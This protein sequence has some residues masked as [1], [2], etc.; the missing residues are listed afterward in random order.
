[1]DHVNTYELYSR[2]CADGSPMK[3]N[4]DYVNSCS[5]VGSIDSN[6]LILAIA[7]SRKMKLNVLD[8]SN[9]LKTSV[10]FDPTERT[11]ITLPPF[12]LKWFLYNWPDYKLPSLL[13]K[14]LVIQCLHSI[15][16]TKDAS[17]RWYHLLKAKLQDLGMTTSML[18]H[19]V[20]IWS[21]QQHTCLSVLETDDLLMALNDDAPFHHFTTELHKMF[22]LTCCHGSVLKFLNLRLIQ[23]PLG[24]WFDQTNHIKTQILDPYFSKTPKTSI[25]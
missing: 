7:T 12:Y 11:C 18:D 21:W 20:F 19:G 24:I 1:M 22:D 5:P 10:V 4:I 6:R 16:G 8:I 25:P 9:A 3:E 2:T 17:N 23:N 13:S 15:Q 14:D